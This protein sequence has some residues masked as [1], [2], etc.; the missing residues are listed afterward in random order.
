MGSSA[1]EDF[2]GVSAW[3]IGIVREAAWWLHGSATDRDDKIPI[4]LESCLPRTL[5]I[6]MRIP[7]VADVRAILGDFS[8]Q[9]S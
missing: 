3:R 6:A 7:T 8:L 1:D 9:K 5:V 4:C 2:T